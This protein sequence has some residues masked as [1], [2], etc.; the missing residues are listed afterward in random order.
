MLPTQQTYPK[1][2]SFLER[3]GKSVSLLCVMC[4]AWETWL[5]STLSTGGK[6]VPHSLS[7]TLELDGDS[8]CPVVVRAIRASPLPEA[9]EACQP[10]A[11][12]C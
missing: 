3:P 5:K 9:A 1:V 8:C 6:D 12:A 4:S 11:V 2:R 10:N 7:A